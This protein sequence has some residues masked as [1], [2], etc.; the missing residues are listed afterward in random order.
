MLYVLFP[1]S[2]IY[3]GFPY[4]LVFGFFAITKAPGSMY[5]CVPLRMWAC[6]NAVTSVF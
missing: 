5:V 2:K 4:G 3:L 6:E 1:L